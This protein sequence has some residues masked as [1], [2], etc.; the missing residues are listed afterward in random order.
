MNEL[1]KYNYILKNEKFRELDMYKA[2]G[3]KSVM[4]HS[5]EVAKECL[6]FARDRKIKVSKDILVESALLHDFYLYDWHKRNIKYGLHGYTHAKVA[7]RNAK[8]YFDVSDEV[9]DNILTH[10]WPLNIT[11]KPKSREG[12][13]LCIADKICAMKETFGHEAK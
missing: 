9:Y 13:V 6:K 3:D 7:A 2:H 5:I 1:S 8:K 11:K 4:K 12:W 10:M